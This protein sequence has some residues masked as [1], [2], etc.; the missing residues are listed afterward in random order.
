MFLRQTDK[1]T[2]S[3]GTGFDLG[4]TVVN[5]GSTLLSR[6]SEGLAGDRSPS[7]PRIADKVHSPRGQSNGSRKL[8]GP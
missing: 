6:Y 8:S 3:T 4:P 5:L 1:V 2:M 7:I